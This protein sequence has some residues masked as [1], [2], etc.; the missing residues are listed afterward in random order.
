MN[1]LISVYIC[2]YNYDQFLD[3]SI[4]SVLNQSYKNYEL[5]IIDD[6]STDNSKK[7]I[8][9]YQTNKKIRVF[10]KENEGLIRSSNF[11][12][13]ASKGKYIIR[14]D[15]DDYL[16][17][18]A[19]LVLLSE[20]KKSKEL[21]LVYPDYYMIDSSGNI[22]SMVQNIDIKQQPNLKSPPHGA[23]SLIKKDCLEEV[24]L[25]DQTFD[26][27][28]G[29]DLYYKLISKY[30][31]ANVSLPLFYYRQHN[32][33]L[34]KN[35]K[36]LLKTRNQILKNV[37][38]KY[39]P[40]SKKNPECC[41]IFPI[42][43]YDFEPNCLALSKLNKKELIYYGLENCLKLKGDFKIILSTSDRDILNKS[44]FFFKNKILYHIR[45]DK[46]SFENTHYDDAIKDAIQ[47]VYK[48]KKP[49]I[50]V[51]L[52]YK[53]PFRDE[54][55]IEK[56]INTLLIHNY[57]LVCGVKKDI[58]N[59][60]LIYGSKGLR[61]LGNSGNNIKFEKKA[62]YIEVGGI[63]VIRYKSFLK[64]EPINKKRIGHIIIDE[65]S[66]IRFKSDEEIKLFK[67]KSVIE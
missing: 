5:I 9:N 33:N 54:F 58:E 47:R 41:I 60:Y 52:D 14:L 6:G 24:G 38:S 3:E 18:N 7:I 62:I 67:M 66:S 46:M 31:I 48:G 28:D 27:Q 42:R 65:K 4:Q 8:N 36:K 53:N 21:A 25:Y 55:L 1:E 50:L 57:D 19:L 20:I 2:N 22:L 23:C 13:R 26:R 45:E 10:Y 37:A 30:Q 49:D 43:G 16:D 17:K 11:A 61:F 15:A 44:K 40:K 51:I 63:N 59:N 32:D 12:I 39:L 56:A 34:T 35:K 64:S 29:V